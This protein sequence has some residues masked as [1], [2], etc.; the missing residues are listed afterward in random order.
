[1]CFLDEAKLP[2]SHSRTW[3]QMFLIQTVP[4]LH[5]VV[6]TQD[7]PLRYFL[8]QHLSFHP[9]FWKGCLL[10]KAS[11]SWVLGSAL[12]PLGCRLR[13]VLSPLG[14]RNLICEMRGFNLH[15]PLLPALI[16]S[17]AMSVGNCQHLDGHEEGKCLRMLLSTSH[18]C[19]PIAGKARGSQQVVEGK[20]VSFL[21]ER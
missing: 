9:T 11:G 14:F 17:G 6:S 4:N 5:T 13:Q 3:T 7:M 12:P 1:M 10:A 19:V 8:Q 16:L 2:I 20:T 21:M 18:T 15:S